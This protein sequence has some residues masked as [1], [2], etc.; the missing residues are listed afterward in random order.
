MDHSPPGPSVQGIS[1]ARILEWVA[2]PF[3]RRSSRPRDQTLVSWISGGFFTVWATREAHRV[4]WSEPKP[5]EGDSAAHHLK[6]RSRVHV[7]LYEQVNMQ[8]EGCV[9]GVDEYRNLCCC[10]VAK[11]CPI[12]CNLMDCSTP[13]FPVLHYL[14]EFA[15]THIHWVS[16]A[17]QPSQ[18]LSSASP[19]AF[20]LSQHQSLFFNELA[21]CIRW[22]KSW[23]FSFHISPSN[24]CS[25]L[26]SFRIDWFDLLAV[27]GTLRSCL[28]HH[29]NLVLD[30]EEG[31][32]LKQSEKNNNWMDDA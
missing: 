8:T 21:L 17:T 24:E 16:D 5:T 1:Q 27:Q 15:Q 6:K 28:Q 14:Q 11:L 18:P 30:D 25:G 19:L 3:S 23:S 32:I 10:S 29:R 9:I 31:V 2:I 4:L 22:P 12:L 26:I 7:W 13:G 20:S